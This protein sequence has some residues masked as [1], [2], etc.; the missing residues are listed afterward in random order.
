MD[1][2]E[3]T[4]E[5]EV[6]VEEKKVTPFKYGVNPFLTVTMVREGRVFRFEMPIGAHLDECVEASTECLNIVKAMRDEAMKKAEAEEKK[7]SEST[8]EDIKKEDK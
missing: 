3:A 2:K 8:D 5:P 4:V 6:K 7:K 1:K